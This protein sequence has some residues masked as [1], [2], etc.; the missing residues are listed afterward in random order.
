MAYNILIPV[1]ALT[2]VSGKDCI[3]LLKPFRFIAA[4][5]PA[6]VTGTDVVIFNNAG[7]LSIKTASG[8]AAIGTGAGVSDGDK[9]DITVSAS[10]ATWT[11]DAGAVTLAKMADMATASLIY[12]KT[13]GTGAPEVQTLATLKADLGLTGTNS[14]DQTSVTGNAGTATA[15]QTGRTINGTTFDGTANI[16]VTAAAGTLT[17]TTLNATVVTTSITSTGTLATGTLGTGYVIAGVTMTLGSDA[18]GDMYYRNASGVLTRIPAG[19]VGHVMK[20]GAS[21]VP[22]WAAESGGG[23]SISD[24]GVCYIRS[25]GNDGTGDGSPG[26]PFLTWQAAIDDAADFVAFD[27]GVGSFG[28]G[29][30][31][32]RIGAL[33][34]ITVRGSGKDHTTVGDVTYYGDAFFLTDLGNSSVQFGDILDASNDIGNLGDSAYA[35]TLDSV[36]CGGVY[37]QGVANTIGGNSGAGAAIT[38][39][40]MCSTGVLNTSGAAGPAGDGGTV[41]G[42]GGAGGAVTINGPSRTG[43]LNLSGGAAGADGGAGAGSAGTG[44]ALTASAGAVFGAVTGAASKSVNGATEDGGFTVLDEAYSATNW[45]GSLEPPTKNAVRDQIEA[46]VVQTV[47]SIFT[48]YTTDSTN[49]PIDDTIPQN[50][51]GTEINTLSITPRSASSKL[52]FN[53]SAPFTHTGTTGVVVALFV[54]STAA[55]IFATV[56]LGGAGAAGTDVISFNFVVDSGSTSART[57]K[58]RFGSSSGNS[59]VLGSTTARRYGGVAAAVL[60]IQEVQ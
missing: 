30:F 48:T 37:V 38:L 52:V 59:Q 23:A 18:S 50:T 51:E 46:R 53:F 12:R 36:A 2:T 56:G 45:N 55:A 25:D 26:A 20:Q 32:A 4:A 1:D 39:N 33:L 7:T 58:I 60:T 14:G 15:L 24:P 19:T 28:P 34:E 29:D 13:A 54:D 49:I 5:A 27:F 41:G 16:T 31:T 3:D 57:Y 6:T 35:C 10:G 9:G 43:T 11:I 22:G 40:G 44:G 8:T 47:S 21:A 17:G 42:N